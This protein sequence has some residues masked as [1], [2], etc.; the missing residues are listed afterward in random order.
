MENKNREAM[1]VL[2]EAKIYRDMKFDTLKINHE[3]DD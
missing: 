1:P 3:D 2:S